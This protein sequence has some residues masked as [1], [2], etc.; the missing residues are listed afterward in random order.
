MSSAGIDADAVF[1]TDAA[2]TPVHVQGWG[3]L[4]DTWPFFRPNFVNMEKHR[5][6][7]R[8]EEVRACCSDPAPS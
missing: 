2:A 4:G 8:A 1:T 6:E 7:C 5:E 3:Y